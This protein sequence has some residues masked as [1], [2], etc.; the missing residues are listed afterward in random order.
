MAGPYI[1]RLSAHFSGCSSALCGPSCYSLVSGCLSARLCGL[2]HS[3][4]R[5]CSDQRG[6]GYFFSSI[7][8]RAIAIL[9]TCLAYNINT[10]IY[11]I[12]SSKHYVMSVFCACVR[13]DMPSKLARAFYRVLEEGRGYKRSLPL[14]TTVEKIAVKRNPA[15]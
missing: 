14:Q 7:R 12:A 1:S 6:L 11:H 4:V 8:A 9:C 13:D 15:R 2:V 5:P 10:A 3:P